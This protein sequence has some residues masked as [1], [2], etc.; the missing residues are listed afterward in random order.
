MVFN[1]LRTWR[2]VK[3]SHFTVHKIAGIS[4]WSVYLCKNY[5]RKCT[6]DV[7][8]NCQRWCPFLFVMSF[9]LCQSVQHPTKYPNFILFCCLLL[10]SG[11][12]VAGCDVTSLGGDLR[13]A[14]RFKE[15][16]PE[17]QTKRTC[18]WAPW[19]CWLSRAEASGKNNLRVS[20]LCYRAGAT[21]GLPS[22]E[23]LL[24]VVLCV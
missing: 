11:D 21:H 15:T 2:R 24:C 6:H 12:H 1:A 4:F 16:E 3:Y 7:D 23:V 10:C 5:V 19:R 8:I 13:V 22:T 17:S 9:R 18:H 14:R 20:G